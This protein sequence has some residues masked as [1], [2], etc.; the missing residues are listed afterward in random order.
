MKQDAYSGPTNIW[1][2]GT[3]FVQP[4]PIPFHVPPHPPQKTYA[5]QSYHMYLHFTFSVTKKH[6]QNYVYELTRPASCQTICSNQGSG[7]RWLPKNYFQETCSESN[8]QF[9][10]C[11]CFLSATTYFICMHLL[12]ISRDHISSLKPKMSHVITI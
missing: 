11:L 5:L 12:S 2:H 4:C 8:P 7:I 10:G 9:Q 6:P 1:F 3:K